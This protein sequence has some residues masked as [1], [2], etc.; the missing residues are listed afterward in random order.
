M[1]ERKVLDV[2]GN[3]GSEVRVAFI[4]GVGISSLKSD[5]YST[6]WNMNRYVLGKDL[7]TK[8]FKQTYDYAH[9]LWGGENQCIIGTERKLGRR[10]ALI[11]DW[12]IWRG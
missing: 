4:W 5:I 3:N 11:E 1:Y 7:G 8:L 10:M 6:T 9:K 2:W 12:S